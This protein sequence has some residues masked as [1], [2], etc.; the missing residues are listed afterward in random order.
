M[1]HTYDIFSEYPGYMTILLRKKYKNRR[2]KKREKGKKRKKHQN[3]R[4]H[5]EKRQNKKRKKPSSVRYYFSVPLLP[6]GS[7]TNPER[8]LVNL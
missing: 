3:I 6:P 1:T 8:T 2:E 5:E 4:K 7:N